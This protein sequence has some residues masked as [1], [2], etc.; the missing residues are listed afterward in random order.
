MSHPAKI[1]KE[2]GIAPLKKFGQNFLIHNESLRKAVPLVKKDSII[3]EIGPGLGAVTEFFYRQNYNL[4]LCEKD[5]KLAEYLSLKYKKIKIY[6][7]DFLEIETKI[8][9]DLNVNVIIGNLPFYIT[10]DII[11]KIMKEMKFVKSAILGIQKEVAERLLKRKESSFAIFV[12]LMGEIKKISLISKKSFYPEPDV[13]A[14]WIYWERKPMIK[15]DQI[16]KMELLLKSLF[17]GKRKKI[18]KSLKDNPFLKNSK[19]P[20]NWIKKIE[21]EPSNEQIK[22]IFSKR[23]DSLNVI[24]FIDLLSYL[25]S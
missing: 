14:M 12:S 24:D 10:S 18:I 1:I 15:D 22:N 9:E 11:V 13:N 17:W 20:I 3:L 16:N 4:V 21:I 8:W 5:R 25:D 2:L 6:N 23:P 19:E 7:E